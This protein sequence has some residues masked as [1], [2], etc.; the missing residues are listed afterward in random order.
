[1]ELLAEVKLKIN[2]PS[3]GKPAHLTQKKSVY[4]HVHTKQ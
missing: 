2:Q 1:M 4:R 3:M